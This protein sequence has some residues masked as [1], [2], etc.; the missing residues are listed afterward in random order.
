MALVQIPVTADS[1]NYVFTITLD[2]IDY[3]MAFRW[4]D[5]YACWLLSFEDEN[6]IPFINSIEIVPG[7]DLLYQLA[8]YPIPQGFLYSINLRDFQLPP[9][10]ENFGEEN[11]VEYDE[12]AT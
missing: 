2:T 1:T 5:R 11:V 3:R 10:Q 6:N 9:T 4:N 8:A 7:L 12:V